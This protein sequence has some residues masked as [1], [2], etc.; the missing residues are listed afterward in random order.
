MIWIINLLIFIVILYAIHSFHIKI[1]FLGISVSFITGLFGQILAV[2]GM[3]TAVTI[4][5]MSWIYN[6]GINLGF[7]ISTHTE[8]S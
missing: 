5:I 2:L 8:A 6:T 3:L 7:P 4:A 1:E